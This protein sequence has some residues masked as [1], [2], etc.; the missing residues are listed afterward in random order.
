MTLTDA[1]RARRATFIDSKTAELQAE[2]A[3]NLI[4]AGWD[5]DAAKAAAVRTFPRRYVAA[6]YRFTPRT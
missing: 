2:S 5:H 1:Q 6:T 3:A 4:R